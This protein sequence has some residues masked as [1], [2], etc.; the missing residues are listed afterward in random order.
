MHAVR[1]EEGLW[2]EVG[3]SG[4]V[5][6]KRTHPLGETSARLFQQRVVVG[7]DRGG[8]RLVDTRNIFVWSCHP[9]NNQQGQRVHERAR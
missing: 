2:G 8:V 6:E 5:E 1:E 4:R 9:I 3:V 7:E